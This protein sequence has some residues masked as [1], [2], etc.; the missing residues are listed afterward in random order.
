MAGRID[1]EAALAK[2]RQIEEDNLK[3]ILEDYKKSMMGCCLCF[4]MKGEWVSIVLCNGLD[5]TVKVIV[6]GI[7]NLNI[8]NGLLITV[9]IGGIL[10]PPSSITGPETPD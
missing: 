8:V 6:D 5:A 9:A 7:N 3:D 10:A 1:T 2:F 4:I